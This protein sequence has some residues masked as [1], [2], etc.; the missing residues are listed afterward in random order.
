MSADKKPSFNYTD[1]ILEVNDNFVRWAGSK[2]VAIPFNATESELFSL[3]R[4]I[5]G[6]LFTGGAL[7]LVDIQTKAQHPYY[8]TAKKIIQY[9]KY[10]KDVKNETW[11]ILGIC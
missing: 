7:T 9:S 11:P 3:L 6:V 4:Q 10:M 1:Y 5:N 8:Q 2:T